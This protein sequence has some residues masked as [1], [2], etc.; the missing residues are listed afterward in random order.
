MNSPTLKNQPLATSTR[1]SDWE[2]PLDLDEGLLDL[3][4]LRV[5]QIH[6]CPSCMEE[7]TKELKARGETDLRLRLLKNW[8]NQAVFSDRE[9]AALNLAEAMTYQPIDSVPTEDLHVARL[10]FNESEMICLTLAIL[11]VNDW[12]YLTLGKVLNGNTALR[13]LHE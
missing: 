6:D 13:S 10:F 7:H 11:A 4:R 9:E 3:V 8:R 1:S 2:A 5:V 12:H